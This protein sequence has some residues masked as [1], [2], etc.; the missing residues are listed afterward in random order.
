VPTEQLETA[1][2]ATRPQ[3]VLLAAQQLQTA[4]TLA[5]I[6]CLLQQA[7]V[8]LAYGGLI[9]N[10]L[11]ALRCRLPAHFLG[12]RLDL[13]P[14]VVESLLLSPR[15]LPTGEKVSEA[16]RRARE[17][18][19][20][21]ANLI[22]ARLLQASAPAGI[23]VQHLALANHELALNIA[24]ALALGDMN[25][26]GTDIEW[27]KGLLS[28]CHLSLKALH[29]YLVAYHCAAHDILDERGAPIVDWLERVLHKNEL[30]AQ[31]RIKID[32]KQPI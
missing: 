31:E 5:E 6:A 23:T 21:Q 29:S 10:L 7:G 24:A 16:Y 26:L 19:H 2:V 25:Y 13:A 32:H 3:L 1:V 14:N 27:V 12:E 15:P 30:G 18:Y 17:H 20:L 8:P 22:A 11:P 28:N 4:A 9:F